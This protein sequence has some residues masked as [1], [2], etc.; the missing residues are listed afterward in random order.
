MAIDNFSFIIA[1]RDRDIDRVVSC[2]NSLQSFISSN[3]VIFVDY[4]SSK[5]VSRNVKNLSLNYPFLEYYNIDSEGLIW[6]KCE[7][8]NY[9]VSKA[10]Y[11]KIVI[12]DIDLIF[13][14]NFLS[15]CSSYDYSKTFL[16][17][18]CYFFSF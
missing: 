2:L 14:D 13:P 8:L 17:F 10:S 15:V 16:T 4:G 6:N 18:D 11:S 5:E 7:A 9:G 12:T 3:E 1:F